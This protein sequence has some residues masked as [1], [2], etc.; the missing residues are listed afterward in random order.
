LTAGVV[1][2]AGDGCEEG[3]WR[4]PGRLGFGLVLDP[5]VVVED[6]EVELEL[7]V[8]VDVGLFDGVVEE[9]GVERVGVE[10]LT[11]GVDEDEDGAHDSLS[12]VITPLTGRFRAEIG[13]PAGA[14]T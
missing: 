3:F 4:L 1:V 8:E 10:A 7:G 5:E 2:V 9:E 14:L 12:D 13:V 6:E 11:V